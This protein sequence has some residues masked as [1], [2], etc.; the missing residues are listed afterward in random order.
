MPRT[1]P[2]RTKNYSIQNVNSA[3]VYLEI[4]QYA[5][6]KSHAKHKNLEWT[7]FLLCSVGN[8]MRIWLQVKR[9]GLNMVLSLTICSWTSRLSPIHILS[10]SQH[11]NCNSLEVAHV[12]PMGSPARGK[13]RCLSQFPHYWLGHSTLIPLPAEG[14]PDSPWAAHMPTHRTGVPGTCKSLHLPHKH[15]CVQE[16]MTLNSK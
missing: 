4:Q 2:S 3:K 13:G 16:N 11:R 12:L 8:E 6:A 15:S 14:N 7:S 5:W 9:L 1:T 10:T